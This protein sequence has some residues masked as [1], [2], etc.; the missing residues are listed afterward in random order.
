M[1]YIFTKVQDIGVEFTNECVEKKL[2]PTLPDFKK[3]ESAI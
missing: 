1:T 2:K 3:A